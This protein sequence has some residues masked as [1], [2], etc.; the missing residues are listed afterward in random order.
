MRR[1]IAS[2]APAP[3]WM[4]DLA[5]ALIQQHPATDFSIDA[6]A[7]IVR[8]HPIL[9]HGLAGTT[10]PQRR[11]STRPA[12]TPSRLALPSLPV[13]ADL[14]ALAPWLELEPG[15]M[16]WLA[17]TFGQETRR[18]DGP[19]RHYRYRWLAREYGPDR[20]IEMPRLRLREV[21]RR[22]HTGLL[23]HVPLHAAA[24][25]FVRGRSALTH[26]RL[27][28]GAAWVLR[29]DLAQFFCHVTAPRVRGVFEL[30]GYSAPVARMLAA[31]CTNRVPGDVLQSAPHALAWSQRQN[32]REAHLPQ[33][34]PTSPALANLVSFGLD[35]R[36]AAL[37]R[38]HAATYSRYADD[39]TF[40]SSTWTRAA[41]ARCARTASEIA[42]ECGF[43][44]NPRKTLLMGAQH[45]Q[46]VTGVVVNRH[47]NLARR[48]YDRLK[49]IV[50]NCLRFG[51]AAQNHAEHPNFRAWLHGSLAQAAAINPAKTAPLL[52]DFA[53][54]RWD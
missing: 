50:H 2:F 5:Q 24:Q 12:I 45:A 17:D 37:A 36:L 51:P 35:V 18:P 6:L 26:A 40:S 46:V 22:I 11:Q 53:R 30:L 28:V 21:Q 20:L 16:T 7:A 14:P 3:P 19:Q 10:P 52:R 47:P 27:H 54:I 4:F 31:L 29:L 15:E 8:H 13:L 43:V 39:L 23:R 34:A 49:A 1:F 32:L 25:G 41:A 48:D 33:G 9:R 44:V 38:K 42:A